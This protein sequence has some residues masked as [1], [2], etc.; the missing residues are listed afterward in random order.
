M[1][2]KLQM[3]CDIL[4]GTVLARMIRTIVL[5]DTNFKTI[6]HHVHKLKERRCDPSGERSRSVL[7][8]SSHVYACKALDDLLKN[9]LTREEN[10]SWIEK[11]VVTRTWLSTTDSNAENPVE[12]LQQTLDTVLHDSGVSLSAPAT[13]AAQ[14]LMWRKAEESS[15]H[16]QHDMAEAWCNL[17]LHPVFEKSGTQNRVKITR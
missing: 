11:A 10:A 6:I 8:M 14:T 1:V 2:S 17:C 16:E 5:N 13:H 7:N 12:Q 15:T 3:T 9:R 4:I